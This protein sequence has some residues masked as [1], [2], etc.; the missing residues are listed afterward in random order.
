MESRK[1]MPSQIW[2]YE[3]DL[4]SS[5]L[6]VLLAL[7]DYGQVAFP[8]QRTLAAKCRL[9]RSRVISIVESLRRKGILTTTG[10]GKSLRYRVHLSH[11]ATCEGDDLS[12][13]A[14]GT[15]RMARQEMS[16]G[17]TPPVAWRDRDQNSP[18]NS[19]TEP[20]VRARARKGGGGMEIAEEPIREPSDPSQ[21][22]AWGWSG[23]DP[24]D[25]VRAVR[26]EP[27]QRMAEAR[28]DGDVAAQRRV[29][30]RELVRIGVRE[31]D[32]SA[33][34]AALVRK[35]GDTGTRPH[36]ILRAMLEDMAGVRNIA[37]VIA[38][39]LGIERKAA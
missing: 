34:W 22:V 8:S 24:A 10:N 19:P 28:V 17:A 37:S 13:G 7:V 3:G 16:H 11:G 26:W 15:C 39:R 33:H 14:T 1:I 25:R 18:T 23:T 38:H 4:T 21:A 9:S 2:E 20:R 12:H 31:D 36:E 30:E 27:N 29:T 35:W 6:I 5:E 32:L